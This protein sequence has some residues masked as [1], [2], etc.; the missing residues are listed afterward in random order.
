MLLDDKE[1]YSS[2]SS[3]CKDIEFASDDEI[4]TAATATPPKRKGRKRR[5][6]EF[7]EC[8][9]LQEDS[10]DPNDDVYMDELENESLDLS[11]KNRN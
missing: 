8:D 2:E 5:D 11:P 6:E 1:N 9:L 3:D 10:N 4:P 7:K